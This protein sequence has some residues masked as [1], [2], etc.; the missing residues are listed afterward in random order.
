MLYSFQETLCWI[1][2]QRIVILFTISGQQ[3]CASCPAS[4]YCPSNTSDPTLYPCPEGY[5]CP[6]GTAHA[7][8]NPCSEGTYN[9]LPLQQ[10]SSSCELCPPGM[11][12]EGQGLEEPTGNCS[13]G[14]FCT[15]GSVSAKPLPTGKLT[16][17]F[18]D[19]SFQLISWIQF[20]VLFWFYSRCPQFH[21]LSA[22]LGAF[23]LEFKC[24]FRIFLHFQIFQW[25]L[26]KNTQ[27]LQI[28]RRP[29][30]IEKKNPS[31]SW[32]TYSVLVP[33]VRQQM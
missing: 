6:V 22:S 5:Y 29:R 8:E 31:R 1:F 3:A 14:W 19:A 12:C 9:G 11:Y 30:N 32:I 17:N 16:G 28:T 33:K 24:F 2:Y 7:Y 18:R 25:H 21:F 27:M 15:G 26:C 4:Y 20:F 23:S 10:N 13:A